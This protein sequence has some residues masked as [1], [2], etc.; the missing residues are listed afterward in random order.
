MAHG[1][2]GDVA[3]AK[4]ILETTAKEDLVVHQ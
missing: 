4:S 2:A 3:K 1:S